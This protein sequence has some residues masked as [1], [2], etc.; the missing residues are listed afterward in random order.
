L[1]LNHSLDRPVRWLVTVLWIVGWVAAP[2]VAGKLEV[3]PKESLERLPDVEKTKVGKLKIGLPEGWAT[4]PAQA[5][6]GDANIAARFRH[7]ELNAHLIVFKWPTFMSFTDEEIALQQSVD[8]SLPGSE[9]RCMKLKRGMNPPRVCG[10]TGTQIQQ[11]EEYKT[12][13]FIGSRLQQGMR[14]YGL[15]MVAVVRPDVQEA[16][17]RILEELGIDSQYNV[18]E[19]HFV[20]IAR[21]M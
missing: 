15:F 11:G 4:E 6:D 20:A 19:P 18:Y 16:L 8:E 2:A 5:G 21:S 3:Y 1:G 10:F 17:E 7:A 13:V 12:H 9:G 14:K